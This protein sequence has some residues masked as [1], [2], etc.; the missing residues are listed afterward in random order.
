MQSSLLEFHHTGE[1]AQ[2]YSRSCFQTL[3]LRFQSQI[4]FYIFCVFLFESENHTYFI[5]KISWASL[6][7]DLTGESQGYKKFYLKCFC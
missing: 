7:F 1:R 2:T 3:K 5:F 4:Y 6:S